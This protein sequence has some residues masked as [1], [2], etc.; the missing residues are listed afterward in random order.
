MTRQEKLDRCIIAS[1]LK[2]HYG[3]VEI[4]ARQARELK[5]QRRGQRD[6]MCRRRK[7]PR[8]NLGA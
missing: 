1:V 8:K 5:Q 2:G 4:L 3:D 7:T 6:G